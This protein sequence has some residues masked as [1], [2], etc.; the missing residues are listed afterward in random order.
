MSNIRHCI[1]GPLSLRFLLSRGQLSY[2]PND[3]AACNNILERNPNLASHRFFQMVFAFLRD[4]RCD[5]GM[6][7]HFQMKG[8]ESDPDSIQGNA[9]M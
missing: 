4:I 1:P 7:F 2:V 5:A 3:L 9:A 8:R 6:A